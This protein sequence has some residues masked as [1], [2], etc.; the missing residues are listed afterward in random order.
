MLKRCSKLK[1]TESFPVIGTPIGRFR[2]NPKEFSKMFPS[3][4]FR[5]LSGTSKYMRQFESSR[6]KSR[7]VV[8]HN[9]CFLVP[10]CWKVLLRKKSRKILKSTSKLCVTNRVVSNVGHVSF[11]R[12]R[13]Q[14]PQVPE[15][16]AVLIESNAKT[17][18]KSLTHKLNLLI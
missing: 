1:T 18:I 12:Q 8:V 16:R 17:N 2:K 3:I 4:Y 14:L 6:G 9:R 11:R 5:K 7:V 10:V 13:R 15:L